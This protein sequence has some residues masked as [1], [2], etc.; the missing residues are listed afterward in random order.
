MFTSIFN[1]SPPTINLEL[2]PHGTALLQRSQPISI[3]WSLACVLV[4]VIGCR[5]T[6]TKERSRSQTTHFR[7]R[8]TAREATRC[9][10]GWW[11]HDRGRVRYCQGHIGLPRGSGEASW[12]RCFEGSMWTKLSGFTITVVH[13]YCPE[14]DVQDSL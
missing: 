6:E 8:E 13:L 4:T 5:G 12:R 9:D 14:A 10:A 1:S 2:W 7:R 3:F 11:G